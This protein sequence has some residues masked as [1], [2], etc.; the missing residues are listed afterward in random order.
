MA[1]N[2]N[3]DEM[4]K[5]LDSINRQVIPDYRYLGLGDLLRVI[6]QTQ[7]EILRKLERQG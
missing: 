7:I 5:W 1:E 3:S 6:A 4:Q 2:L